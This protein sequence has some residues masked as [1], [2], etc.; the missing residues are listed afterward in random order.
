[1]VQLSVAVIGAGPCGLAATKTLLQAGFAVTCFE[2]SDVWGGH[3]VINNT[4]GCSAAYE[5]L[6]TNTTKSMSRFS[7]FEM[8]SDWPE[9]PAHYQVRDWLDDY[10][11]AFELEPHIELNTR[12]TH[13]EPSATG[14]KIRAVAPNSTT[15]RDFDALVA[16]SGNY[17][18]ARLPEFR[19][20]F[21]GEMFHAQQYRSPNSPVDVNNKVVVVVGSGNTGCEL[22]LEISRAGAHQVYLSARSGNWIMPKYVDGSRGPVS[23]AANAPMSHPLDPVPGVLKVLP[24]AAREAIFTHLGGYMMRKR[25]GDLQAELHKAGLPAAPQHPLAKRPAVAQ[26]LLDVLRCGRIIAVGAIEAC[27]GKTLSFHSGESIEADVVVC[28]TGYRLTYPYLDQEVLDTS[29]DDM[30]LFCGLMHPRQHH[31]FVVG[32]SRPTGGFWPIAEVQAMFI[33]ELLSGKYV[34]PTQK[35]IDRQ[36]QPVLNRMAFNPALYNL[37]LQEE[38]RRGYQRVQRHAG[39]P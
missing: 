18:D 17:W 29:H 26:G 20:R 35:A 27:T 23:I 8:P 3:W 38:L 37:A 16:A 31:L 33:A 39:A 12:V 25:F 13:A 10:V 24:Q 22:A 11:S 30:Q 9:F 5:S 21:S 4:N 28:A 2:S 1:M 36:T 32:V 19:G 15:V 14:W 34:L 6:T 7:D